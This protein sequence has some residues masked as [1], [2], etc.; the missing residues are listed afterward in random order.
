ME[1]VSLI[2]DMHVYTS[3]RWTLAARDKMGV[4]RD[5]TGGALEED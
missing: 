2:E 4:Y 5:A 1:G 3:G